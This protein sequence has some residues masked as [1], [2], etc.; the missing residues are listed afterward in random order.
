MWDWLAL[1]GITAFFAAITCP[2]DRDDFR[3]L[4]GRLTRKDR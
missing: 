2:Y 1:G 3:A 4:W